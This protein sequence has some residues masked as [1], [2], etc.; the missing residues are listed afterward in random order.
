MV[1]IVISIGYNKSSNQKQICT[2]IWIVL[3]EGNASLKVYCFIQ[4][5]TIIF[6]YQSKYTLGHTFC[7]MLLFMFWN[8]SGPKAKLII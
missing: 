4:C 7:N 1:E 2:P 6:Y 3:K 5:C 8:I